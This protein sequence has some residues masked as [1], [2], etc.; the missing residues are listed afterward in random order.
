MQHGALRRL[1]SAP[2]VIVVGN[3]K[4]GSGKTTLA[5]HVAIGLLKAGQKVAA[6]DLDPDQRSLTCYI[7][8]RRIW[9]NHQR[10]E[11]EVPLHRHIAA[12][13]GMRAD[14]N[15]AKELDWLQEAIASFEASCD[16]L[17]IDT[18]SHD[19]Y[20]MRVAHLAADTILTPLQDSFLDLCSLGLIDP[21]TH[22]IIR[23]GHYATMVCA[24]RAKRRQ[25]DPGF[26]DWVVIR[27]RMCEGAL[28]KHSLAELGLRVGFRDAEGS[29]ERAVYRQF[30]PLG[31]TAFDPPDE[32]T[33]GAGPNQSH[34]AAQ[35]EMQ[36]LFERLQLP[37]SE[38]GLRRAAARSEWSL[39]KETPLALDEI[40]ADER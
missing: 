34:L 11:L 29:A 6:L 24:A 4:G 36:A 33:P 32:I 31:M 9:A 23:T 38:R 17:V 35:A 15:E 2:Y 37:I 13:Q 14:E 28:V 7:E 25:L 20:L 26:I 27:N 18:P 5:M 3:G 1:R 22:E 16:F 21:V 12:A 39:R 10:I 8:N 19:S 40:L 30:F